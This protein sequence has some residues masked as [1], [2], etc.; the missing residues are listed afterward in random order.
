MSYKWCDLYVQNVIWFDS[1]IYL[2]VIKLIWNTQKP[3]PEVSA[4]NS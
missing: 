4:E 1:L 2:I 3:K